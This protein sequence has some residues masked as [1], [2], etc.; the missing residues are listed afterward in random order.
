MSLKRQMMRAAGGAAT[1]AYMAAAMVPTTAQAQNV[2]SLQAAQLA[3]I[4]G[5]PQQ[6][7]QG[8][9]DLSRAANDGYR[10]LMTQLSM[11]NLPMLALAIPGLSGGPGPAATGTDRG[12]GMATQLAADYERIRATNGLPVPPRDAAVDADARAWGEYLSGQFSL[13]HDPET[14]AK[15]QGEA[16]YWTSNADINAVRGAI[17]TNF[18]NSPGHR[19][20][21]LAQPLKAYG[22][23]VVPNRAK[24][25]WTVVL[26][27]VY[28]Y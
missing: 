4:A 2:G 12:D 6:L 1:V 11:F 27:T 13:F 14:D 8:S 25:G 5:V 3:P 9:A 19:E 21:M 26:K 22:I 16:I 17:T 24:G 15:N 23:A 18:W 20:V 28:D 7:N 10:A